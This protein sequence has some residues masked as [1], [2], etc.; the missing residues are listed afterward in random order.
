MIYPLIFTDDTFLFSII[1]DSAITT[2]ELDSDLTGTKQWDFQWKMK[3][4]PDFNW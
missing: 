1:H 3:F 4:E 2:S